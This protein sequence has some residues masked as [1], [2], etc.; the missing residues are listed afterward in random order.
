[1]SNL[2]CFTENNLFSKKQLTFYDKDIQCFK[3]PLHIIN[4]TLLNDMCNRGKNINM[5]NKVI[6]LSLSTYIADLIT[7][8]FHSYFI[9]RNNFTGSSMYIDKKLKKIV[10]N[11][12][13]GYSTAHH[14]FPS[15]WKDIDDKIIM[16]DVFIVLSPIFISNFFN[17]NNTTAFLNYAI[18][19]QLVISGIAHKYAHERNH[20]RYVP[21]S[22]K[23][24]QDLKNGWFKHCDAV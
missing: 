7:A 21:E 9:D 11:T 20:N 4:I 19:Y 3:I 17:K 22:I 15:N 13:N 10:I 6:C 16:R 5:T 12:T 14:L 23:I 18:L 2:T 1:M 24:L 8:L